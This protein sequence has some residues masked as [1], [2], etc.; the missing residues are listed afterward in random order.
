MDIRLKL[1]D[2]VEELTMEEY[3]KLLFLLEEKFKEMK[4]PRG[5]LNNKSKVYLVRTLISHYPYPMAVEVLEKALSK[6]PRNDL[7]PI[8]IGPPKRK[9]SEG[10][11]AKLQQMQRT[12]E[13]KIDSTPEAFGPRI[14]TLWELKAMELNEME[15][16]RDIAV[17][18]KIIEKVI[19]NYVNNQKKKMKVFHA[20]IADEN[21]TIQVKVYNREPKE[22]YKGANVLI[23]N[24]KFSNGVMEVTKGSQITKLSNNVIKAIKEVPV[25]S[26][27]EIKQMPKGTFV[28]G[29]FEI[30]KVSR[31]AKESDVAP[32]RITVTDGFD[33]INV[34]IFKPPTTLFCE[35]GRELKMLGIKVNEYKTEIQ[36]LHQCD[37]YVKV[38]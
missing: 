2:T 35:I 29:C 19:H 4:I 16:Q 37:S 30:T 18:G 24:F 5:Q 33:E 22:F 38:L 31:P 10:K 25:L 17:R 28:N 13:R 34:I 14:T 8:E 7:L 9:A 27:R 32:L 12:K 1:L 20:I 3:E 15:Y 21:D 26:L 11:L 23:T 36:L 6:I